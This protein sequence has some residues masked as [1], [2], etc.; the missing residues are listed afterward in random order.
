MLHDTTAHWAEIG[1]M[2]KDT[3]S[4]ENWFD[5]QSFSICPGRDHLHWK[6]PL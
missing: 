5:E 1:K 2:G 4:D 6:G 3:L